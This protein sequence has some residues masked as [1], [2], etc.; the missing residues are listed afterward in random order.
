MA[1]LKLYQ[2]MKLQSV[3]LAP[4]YDIVSSY[5]FPSGS[6]EMGLPIM[7]EFNYTLEAICR[8]G[9][10]MQVPEGKTIAIARKVA[11]DMSEFIARFKPPEIVQD[12]GMRGVLDLISSKASAR[13]RS[14]FVENRRTRNAKAR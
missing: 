4:A 3:R 2:K 8:L 7:G 14:I 12:Q 11:Y 6:T 10:V 9:S 13:M 5:A 1:V